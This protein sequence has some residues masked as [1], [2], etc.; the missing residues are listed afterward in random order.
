LLKAYG[1]SLV[2]FYLLVFLIFGIIAPPITVAADT[3][4]EQNGA[5][6]G[7]SADFDEFEDEFSETSSSRISDPLS[8]YN[9]FA[10]RFNDKFYDWV[11]KPL[12]KGYQAVVPLPARSS[13]GRFFRNLY[14]PVRFANNLL[15]LKFKNAA[16]ET[17]RFTVNSTIG[18]LGFL[19]PAWTWLELEPHP[20]DF[21][22]TLGFYGLGGGFHIVVPFLGPSNLRDLVGLGAD[23]YA[24]LLPYFPNKE[25]SEVSLGAVV[26]VEAFRR[27]NIIS[28][29]LGTYDII[30]KDSLDLYI[31]LRNMYE[32]NRTML[33][34]E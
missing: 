33:I 9:R 10:T 4:Q 12:A 3:P 19:D 17:A 34:K 2:V 28:L 15:Q 25:P 27:F 13:I 7:D 21:G 22:Q 29:E 16:I 6:D 32:E 14:F 30:R 18:L 24:I 26:G 11:A 5:E 20:E 23:G 1:G 31:L 8:G